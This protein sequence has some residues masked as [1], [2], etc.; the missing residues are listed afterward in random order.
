VNNAGATLPA[1]GNELYMI[2]YNEDVS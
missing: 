1:S 2:P